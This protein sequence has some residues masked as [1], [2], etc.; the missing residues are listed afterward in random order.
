MV[1]KK[2]HKKMSKILKI[3]TRCFDKTVSKQDKINHHSKFLV[4]ALDKLSSDNF[5]KKSINCSV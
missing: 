3:K 1:H 5:L 4:E 2:K